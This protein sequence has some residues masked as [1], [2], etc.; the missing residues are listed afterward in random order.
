M[1]KGGV[2]DWGVRRRT[3]VTR[4]AKLE[5]EEEEEHT[6]DKDEKHSEEHLGYDI[7]DFRMAMIEGQHPDGKPLKKDMPRWNIGEEDL[8]GLANY[9]KSLP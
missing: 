1:I 9:L 7:D 4:W 5:H 3:R 8:V 6:G 2:S